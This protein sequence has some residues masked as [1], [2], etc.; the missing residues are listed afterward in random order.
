MR[1]LSTIF[2][3]ILSS[4]VVYTGGSVYL[5]EEP[6][7]M[8]RAN[9][10]P[11]E[12][13]R[14]KIFVSG[15]NYIK[16][17]VKDSATGVILNIVI[18]NEDFAAFLAVTR[19]LKV[20]EMGRFVDNNAYLKFRAGD[21]FDYMTKNEGKVV[22]ITLANLEKSVSKLHFGKE[23]V[24]KEYLRNYILIFDQPLTFEQ[25]G[26]KTEK[27]LIGKYFDFDTSTGV[28]K[29]KEVYYT[30]HKRNEYSLNPSFIATLLDLGLIVGQ[31]DII[32]ILF[33][34]KQQGKE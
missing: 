34:R 8:E 4:V 30:N 28:G 6:R 16:V 14:Y 24:P 3:V 27:E 13:S 26:V 33:I 23:K 29:L 32:P 12:N 31:T 15:A 5:K 18:D 2:F 19:G 25:L 7:A 21:Y 22:E 9:K 17:R 20:D 1:R 11:L 10:S